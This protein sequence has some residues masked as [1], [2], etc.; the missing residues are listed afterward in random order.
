MAI[1]RD[2]VAYRG[3]NSYFFQNNQEG[4]DI[5]ESQPPRLIILQQ[6]V[7]Q[8]NTDNLAF[9]LVFYFIMIMLPLLMTYCLYRVNNNN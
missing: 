3:L 5:Q 2:L 8:V 7:K 4:S 9:Y 1:S 6:Q